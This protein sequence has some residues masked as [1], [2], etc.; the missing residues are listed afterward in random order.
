MISLCLLVYLVDAPFQIT[1]AHFPPFLHVAAASV[2]PRLNF[3]GAYRA[4]KVLPP[5]PL[6]PIFGAFGAV[7]P[8]AGRHDVAGEI[9]TTTRFGVH[10]VHGQGG[11]INRHAVAIRATVIPCRFDPV[12]PDPPGFFTVH[13]FQ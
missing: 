1:Y 2:H 6:Q 12:P 9:F 8:A 13:D 4:E 3:L 7:A 10:V 5:I 11:I